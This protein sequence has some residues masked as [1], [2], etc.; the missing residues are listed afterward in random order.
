MHGVWERMIRSVWQIL[1]AVLRE[2]L[3]T[4]EMLP[5]VIAEAANILNSQPLT[6]N[7]DSPYYDLEPL[8]PNHLLHLHPSTSL[9]PTMFERNDLYC[10]TFAI[11]SSKCILVKADKR[12]FIDI[13]GEEKWNSPKENLKVG[14]VVLLAD[15]AYPQGQWPTGYCPN[16]L[17]YPQ[18]PP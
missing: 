1:Q 3:V 13:N 16:C 14:D 18:K 11:I 15:E 5:T 7:S 12:I 6:R 8:T 10:N 4:D 2:K 17:F 9:P